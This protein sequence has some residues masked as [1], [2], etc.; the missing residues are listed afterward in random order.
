MKIIINVE[1]QIIMSHIKKKI[2]IHL[3]CLFAIFQGP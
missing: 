3:F 1:N 2:G